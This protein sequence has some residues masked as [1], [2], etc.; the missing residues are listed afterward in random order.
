MKIYGFFNSIY[1]FGDA[2]G[3]AITEDGY[4]VG[5]HVSSN[6]SFSRHDLYVPDV[7]DDLF[8]LGWEWEFVS[9]KDRDTHAGLKAAIK[10]ASEEEWNDY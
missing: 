8:P 10:V 3:V 6:E 1:E 2:V 9:I 7:F 5:T 4:V